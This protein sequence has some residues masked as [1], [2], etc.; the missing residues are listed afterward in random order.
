MK[1]TQLYKEIE[2]MGIPITSRNFRLL[3]EIYRLKTKLINLQK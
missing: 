3:I 2:R 1:F